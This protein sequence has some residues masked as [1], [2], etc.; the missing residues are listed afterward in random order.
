MPVFA[1]DS[2]L[3]VGKEK[4]PEDYKAISS[5]SRS[6]GKATSMFMEKAIDP[7][8]SRFPY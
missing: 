8:A 7:K 4:L 2:T 3:A 5:D 6:D 1:M